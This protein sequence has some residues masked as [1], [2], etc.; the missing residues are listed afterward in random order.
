MRKSASCMLKRSIPSKAC[1]TEH[2]DGYV[3][4]VKQCGG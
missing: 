3:L 1:E 4:I 2:D